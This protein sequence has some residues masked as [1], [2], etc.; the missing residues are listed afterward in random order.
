[1]QT[2]PELKK[3]FVDTGKIRYGYRDTVSVGG[4]YTVKAARVG[5]CVAKEKFWDYHKAVYERRDEW[6]QGSLEQAEAFFQNL[7][8]SSTGRNS[9]DFGTCSGSSGTNE[10]IQRDIAAAASFGITGTPSFVINGYMFSGA[11]PLEVY[12]EIFKKFGVS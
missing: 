4:E 7:A 2:F 9:A 12:R 10:A 5:N 11:L 1:L 8:A 3:E 6:A